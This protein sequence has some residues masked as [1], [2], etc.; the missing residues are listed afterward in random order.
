MCKPRQLSQWS[1]KICPCQLEC[2]G[3]W[4]L[5]L[6]SRPVERW[7]LIAVTIWALFTYAPLRNP[8]RNKPDLLPLPTLLS[9][10]RSSVMVVSIAVEQKR[11]RVTHRWSERLGVHKRNMWSVLE[12]SVL[13]D[14]HCLTSSMRNVNK[15][16]T[17]KVRQITSR[18]TQRI[19]LRLIQFTLC[20]DC[21]FHATKY[22]SVPLL[23]KNTMVSH[24]SHPSYTFPKPWNQER[25]AICRFLTQ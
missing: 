24:I 15:S 10:C 8:C 3:T 13:H 2:S 18:E 25:L 23:F 21:T 20:I 14:K 12:Q 19:F 17:P 1:P 16:E 7:P 4:L 5:S 11:A 22:D 6:G 9:S